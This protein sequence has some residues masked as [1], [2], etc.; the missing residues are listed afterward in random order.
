M[1][2]KKYYYISDDALGKSALYAL[3]DREKGITMRLYNGA[4]KNGKIIEG[5]NFYNIAIGHDA[6]YNGVSEAEFKKFIKTL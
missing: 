1:I 4:N 2:E 6:D 5:Q 3:F